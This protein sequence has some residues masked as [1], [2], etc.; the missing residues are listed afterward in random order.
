MVIL[1]G[2]VRDG[3]QTSVTPSGSTDSNIPNAELFQGSGWAPVYTN[4][5]GGFYTSANVSLDQLTVI[6]SGYGVQTISI[7]VYA[8]FY[9]ARGVVSGS[10]TQPEVVN[11]YFATIT[12]ATKIFI[13]N[14]LTGRILTMMN[15]VDDGD[16]AVIAA[17]TAN[18]I[19][20]GGVSGGSFTGAVM[21]TS[22]LAI[23]TYLPSTSSQIVGLSGYVYT[24][25]LDLTYYSSFD[26]V[27]PCCITQA[28]TSGIVN[29]DIIYNN[30]SSS[31]YVSGNTKQFAAVI[32]AMGVG[33]MSGQGVLLYAGV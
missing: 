7:P 1:A 33:I 14:S 12:D 6:A 24:V 15:G 26:I 31:V 8:T 17:N 18:T 29:Q 30:G 13:P 23:G 10:L 20:L 3:T 5:S 27:A 11:G 25:E 2:N 28:N 4:A 32:Y 21:N 9:D 16:T 19:T 22:G